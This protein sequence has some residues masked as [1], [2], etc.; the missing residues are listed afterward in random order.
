MFE[1]DIHLHFLATLPKYNADMEVEHVAGHADTV[2]KRPPERS[3]QLTPN[4][5]G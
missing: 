5:E 3:R 4:L 1:L 2:T